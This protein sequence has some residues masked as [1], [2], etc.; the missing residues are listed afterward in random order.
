MRLRRSPHRPNLPARKRDRRGRTDAQGRRSRLPRGLTLRHQRR[1]R[2]GRRGRH[3]RRAL[4]AP[5]KP[6]TYKSP[7]PGGGVLFT[8]GG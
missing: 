5:Q 2:R 6:P 8:Q 1:P 4:N 3:L 7:T